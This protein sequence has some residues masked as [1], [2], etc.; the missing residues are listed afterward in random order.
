ML[1]PSQ[2]LRLDTALRLASLATIAG[3]LSTSLAQT[4]STCNPTAGQTCPA[5]PALGGALTI[6]FTSGASSAFTSSGSPTYDS[7]GAHFTVAKSGD[8]PTITSKFYIMF[9]KYSITMKAAPGQGIVSSAVLQSD[10]LD[11]IDWEWLGGRDSEVQSNYF[12]KGQSGTGRSAILPVSQAQEQFHTYTI[13]WTST[14]IVWQIDGVTVEAV[15]AST[16]GSLYPQTPMQ[17]KIGAWAGGDPTNPPGTIAWAGGQTNYANGPFTMTVK[18][19]DVQD[20]STGSSYSYS[21][22]TGTWQSIKSN[23]GTINGGSS[24]V[25]TS[26]PQVTSTSSG[27]EPWDGTHR[28]SSSATTPNAGG[29]TVSTVSSSSSINTNLP[30][31]PSGWTVSP[32]GKVVP[33]SSSATVIILPSS[34]IYAVAISFT[35]GLVFGFWG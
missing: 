21:G 22:T 35:T 7:T 26:A 9:G 17:L 24:N 13:E 15:Q 18:S 34:F 11:E 31:L 4:S 29:W 25:D 1:F 14:Q 30:G 32:S 20:Y 23:G 33:L 16:A 27:Q 8:A 6:D 5:D 12:S 10:D 3:L 19:V 2:I 28:S